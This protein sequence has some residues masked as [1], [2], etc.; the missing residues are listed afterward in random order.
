LG[1]NNIYL[2]LKKNNQAINLDNQ[3]IGFKWFFNLFFDFL[4]SDLLQRGNIVLMDE[5]DAHLSLPDRK[6]LIKFFT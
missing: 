5:P 4:H 6:D 2:Y 3:S 1:D